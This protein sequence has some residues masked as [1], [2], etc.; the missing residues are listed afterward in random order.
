LTDLPQAVKPSVTAP[1]YEPA[2]ELPAIPGLVF[3]HLE[4]PADYP[5]MNAVANAARTAEGM[6]YY[7]S[8]ADFANFYGHLSN[9]DP[10]RDVVVV[11][12]DGA[13]VGYAR[14]TWY[15]EHAGV[16]IYE[17]ICFLH[18]DWLRRGIGAAMLATNEARLRQ[19]ASAH[20][21][22]EPRFFQAETSDQSAGRIALLLA[23]GYG[24]IRH[25]YLM[26][27]P[28]LDDQPDAPLPRGLEIR[29]VRPDHLRAIWE[30]DQEAF[31][32]HWG[33]GA[34]GEED[35]Q[36]FA[37]DPTQGDTSL[38][39]IAWDGDQ[40]AGQVRSYI[41]AAENDKFGRRRGWVENISVR[42]PW[43]G[44]GLARALMAASFPLLQARGMTEGALT[45]DTE[46]PGALHLYESVGFKA[47]SG[48]TTYRKAFA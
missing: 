6:H 25:G 7:T 18:P 30:A 20:P 28:N 36:A 46:N 22:D 5:H 43:R 17:N 4:P 19:V 23:A 2:V 8:D 29:E 44:R 41:N 11:E 12:I 35:Y 14:S 26:V 42:R 15:R 34:R 10:A 13:V 16:W 38:W 47:V 27:R 40:V 21:G 3:R 9:C 1:P 32:D 39:R 33:S 24:P 45:V 37:T 31:R 48:D